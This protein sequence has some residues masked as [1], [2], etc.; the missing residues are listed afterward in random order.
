MC[1]RDSPEPGAP[2][3]LISSRGDGRV[4]CRG[5]R[6]GRGLLRGGVLYCSRVLPRSFFTESW[7]RR[8][9]SQRRQ[10]VPQYR[11]WRVPRA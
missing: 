5:K 11:T 1:I 10:V 7:Y 4:S 9:T 8:S 3:D 6:A 2:A